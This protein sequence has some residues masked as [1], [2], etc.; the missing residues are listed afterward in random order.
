MVLPALAGSARAELRCWSLGCASEEEP[1]T[2][3]L[4]WRLALSSRYP[5]LTCRI[6]ATDAD[7]HLPA[8]VTGLQSWLPQFGFY[9]R[10][11][12]IE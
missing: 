8:G 7:E 11:H 2:L 5:G 4:V 9:R 6:L 12:K 10:S 3:N 1:Y